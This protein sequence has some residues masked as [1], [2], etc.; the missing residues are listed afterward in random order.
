MF[1]EWW[2]YL[3]YHL[4][5]IVFSVGSFSLHWYAVFFLLGWG[6]AYAAAMVRFRRGESPFA[7]DELSDIFFFVLFG[8]LIGARLGYALFY[9]RLLFVHPI[10][11]VSPYDAATHAWRGVSGM[12]YF[13]G[14]I[15]VIATLVM[16][17]R[18]RRWNFWRLTDFLVPLV[19]VAIFF[20]RLG[21]FFNVELIGRVTDSPFGMYFLWDAT[22]VL[23]HPSTLYEGC[24][25][26]AL[27]FVFFWRI[28]NRKMV[29]GVLSALYLILYGTAR[30]V[31]EYFRGPEGFPVFGLEK[32]LT[33]GQVLA[34]LSVVSGSMLLW[35]FRT[36]KTVILGKH[37]V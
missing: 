9:D 35:W 30:F 29:P 8:A 37:N 27:L 31:M 10:G 21:N 15:G 33:I 11:L 32:W 5:P 18:K 16:L 1:V 20:G 25:E 22:P 28:R 2:Q 3:P 34:L 26:G 6:A 7:K 19:P 12:S 24:F 4:D 17:A 36:R 13:G 23:R 14:L